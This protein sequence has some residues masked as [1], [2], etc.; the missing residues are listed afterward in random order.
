[1]YFLI[2]DHALLFLTGRIHFED[3]NLD[4]DYDPY[5]SYRQSKL[6]NVLFSREL[7]SRLKGRVIRCFSKI[8]NAC[9]SSET[10]SHFLK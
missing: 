1:M 3:I 6:A 10:V 8:C 7:A 4:K 5:T 9:Y 2:K